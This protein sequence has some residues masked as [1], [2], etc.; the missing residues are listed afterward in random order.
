VAR[1]AL[2][3][4][5]NKSGRHP[6]ATRLGCTC[7]R[8]FLGHAWRGDLPA[9]VPAAATTPLFLTADTGPA[10]AVSRPKRQC[11]G[12]PPPRWSCSATASGPWEPPIREGA[13]IRP[14]ASRI[15]RLRRSVA[16][17]VV[18]FDAGHVDCRSTTEK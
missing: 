16:L 1:A 12:A 9:V 2:R 5:A 10:A 15:A 11:Q 4:A 7:P 8:T 3:F 18:G 13:R 14:G 17:G 6:V